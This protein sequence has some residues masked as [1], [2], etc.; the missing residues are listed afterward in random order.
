MCVDDTLHAGTKEYSDRCENAVKQF[1]YKPEQWDYTNFAGITMTNK[2]NGC[3][4]H[5]KEYLTR[6]KALNKF[7]D[8]LHF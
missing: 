1:T 2:T 5:Q 8:I 3:D 7:S 4:I 6:L